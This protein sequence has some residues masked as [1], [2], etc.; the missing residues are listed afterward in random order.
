MR[1]NRSSFTTY[2]FSGTATPTITSI[3]TSLPR[4]SLNNKP[5]ILVKHA[6][7]AFFRIQGLSLLKYAF[8]R[9]LICLILQLKTLSMTAMQCGNLQVLIF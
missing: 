8:F 2:I 5:C 6:I 9:W 7:Q 3:T 1:K 4:E